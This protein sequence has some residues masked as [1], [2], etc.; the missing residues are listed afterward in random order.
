[1]EEKWSRTGVR[2]RAIQISGMLKNLDSSIAAP[3]PSPLRGWWQF[4]A[5]VCQEFSV[6]RLFAWDFSSGYSVGACVREPGLTKKLRRVLEVT[7]V[8]QVILLG[9]WLF[10]SLEWTGVGGLWGMICWLRMLACITLGLS[11]EW[12]EKLTK[13]ADLET[14]RRH[15]WSAQ[16]SPHT[17]QNPS[18]LECISLWLLNIHLASLRL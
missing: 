14:Y 16:L 12:A 17:C 11:N 15:P 8:G 3:A 10:L 4:S 7:K 2:M 9:F 13:I 5:T 1:M 18:A 6:R